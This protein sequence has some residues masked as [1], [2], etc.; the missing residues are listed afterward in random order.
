MSA[1]DTLSTEVQHDEPSQ[2]V[3]TPNNLATAT[4]ISTH[5]SDANKHADEISTLESQNSLHPE[6]KPTSKIETSTTQLDSD[7]N[8]QSTDLSSDNNLN[9]LPTTQLSTSTNHDQDANKQSAI[10]STDDHGSPSQPAEPFTSEIPDSD[11]NKITTHDSPE[12]ST[13]TVQTSTQDSNFVDQT[14]P[15]TNQSNQTTS[16]DIQ[17]NRDEHGNPSL[18]TESSNSQTSDSDANKQANAI[19]THDSPNSSTT[20]VLTSNQD[21]TSVDQSNPPTTNSDTKQTT[22]G[23][24][25]TTSQTPDSDAS[26]QANTTA[27]NDLPKSPTTQVLTSNQDSN[28]VDEPNPPTTN[29]DSKQATNQSTQTNSQPSEL[30]DNK[31]A[32]T[33]ATHDSQ[34]S[35]TPMDPTI[36]QDSNSVGQTNASKDESDTKQATNENIDAT[37]IAKDSP[38]SDNTDEERKH[39][40][41]LINQDLQ[42]VQDICPR[43]GKHEEN[44]RKAADKA[45]TDFKKINDELCEIKEL[46]DLKKTVTKLKLEIPARYRTYD[47]SEK[48]KKQQF[49]GEN[50]AI[51]KLLKKLPRLHDKLFHGSP[52]CK[53]IQL[54]FNNLESHLKLCL[55]CFSVFPENAIISRRSMVYWWIGEGLTPGEDDLEGGSTAE[56]SA[57]EYF[58]K[59]MDM[60]FIEPV[61]SSYRRY[62]AFCKMHPMV[63]AALVMIADKINFFDFDKKMIITKSY[64]LCLMGSGLSK[65]ITWEKLHMLFNVGDIVLEFKPEWFLRM[66]NINVLFLG[67]WKSSAAHHIEVDEFELEKSLDN[68]NH[69]RL[70]SLQGVSRISKLPDSIS[71]LKSLLILDLRACHNLEEIPKTIGSLKCLTHLDIS[72]CYLLNK[73]PREICYLESLQVLKGFVVV[74]SPERDTCTLKDLKILGNLRK[75]N[76]YT[77]MKEFPQESHLEDLQNLET[78]RKL[79]ILWGGHEA[80]PKI[81]NSNQQDVNKK[82]HSLASKVKKLI[83][84]KKRVQGSMRRMNAFS[85]ST[86]G[87]RLEKLDL[88]CFPHTDEAPEWLKPGNLK[89]L[90]KLYIRGGGFS[91]LGQYQEDFQWDEHL[92]VPPIETWDVEILRLKYLNELK[93]EWGELQSLFPKLISL[94]KVKCHRLTLFPCNEHGVWKGSV[95]LDG[96]KIVRS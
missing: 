95:P 67:R 75:L 71:K 60:G 65:G 54:H 69:L 22:N 33:I 43:L 24:T 25:Q 36:D 85:N 19:A 15:P 83:S 21:S 64:K 31:Q 79:T 50:K 58:Q 38:P 70:F 11:A 76:M 96:K 63:R 66:K 20:K 47:E 82:K 44:I 53:A 6:I 57:N 87:A 51:S 10:T 23:S 90:K 80:T 92:P 2:T 30:D 86:L 16:T 5:D 59:L 93:I 56:D 3:N 74:E 1:A 8:K 17:T 37:S 55:L 27:P 61:S 13:T 39:L 40:V 73:I 91:D 78:L 42:F 68:M 62:V 35:P 7:A 84:K 14:N 28:V 34:E 88:K 46:K 9:P 77:H 52:F 32:N 12:S 49:D 81:T 72:E 45:Y 48:Q 41:T 94:E 29:S 4:T 26:K 89:G 18:V